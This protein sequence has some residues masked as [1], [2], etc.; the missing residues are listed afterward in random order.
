MLMTLHLTG[1]GKVPTPTHMGPGFT[2]HAGTIAQITQLYLLLHGPNHP[3]TT[4]VGGMC[5]FIAKCCPMWGSLPFSSLLYHTP[6]CTSLIPKTPKTPLHPISVAPSL[7]SSH[8]YLCILIFS[9]GPDEVASVWRQQNLV[10]KK[11]DLLLC[12]STQKISYYCYSL[13]F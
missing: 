7:V 4:I 3:P 8:I 9:F 11:C 12:F 13:K 5:N 2:R 10:F 6:H 1:L